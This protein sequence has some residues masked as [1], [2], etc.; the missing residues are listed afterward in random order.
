MRM[1]K[2]RIKLKIKKWLGRG[3]GDNLRG[4][5]R[6]NDGTVQ[7]MDELV[8]EVYEGDTVTLWLE[9]QDEMP[10]PSR[11]DLGNSDL[12]PISYEGIATEV[13]LGD[14][15][16]WTLTVNGLPAPADSLILGGPT[17]QVT[18][19][20]NDPPGVFEEHKNLP[21]TLGLA[22]AILAAGFV[23][24]KYFAPDDD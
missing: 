21:L 20:E 12:D 9:R 2:L 6:I 24:F 18:I 19:C 1:S 10:I 23:L 4:Y 8:F 16:K 5:Y 3:T 7:A 14:S 13:K 22:G 11:L 17:I 15:N